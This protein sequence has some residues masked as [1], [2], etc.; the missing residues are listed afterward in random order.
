MET[1]MITASML[2]T[3]VQLIVIAAVFILGVS[4][5]IIHN[6]KKKHKRNNKQ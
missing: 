2:R 5:A 1:D 4:V 6:Q 3:E